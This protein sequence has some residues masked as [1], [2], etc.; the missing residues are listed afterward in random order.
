MLAFKRLNQV[1]QSSK[2]IPISNRS[3]I[4][5]MSDC[6]R[7]DGSAADDFKPNKRLYMHA[8][9]HYYRAGYTYIEI[10]DADELWENRSFRRILKAHEDVFLLLR[11]FHVAKRFYVIW[12]NH[13]IVKRS[14][15]YLSYNLYY[16]RDPHTRARVPLLEG[17]ES[18]EGLILRHRESNARVFVVHGHQADFF[19]DQLWPVSCMLVRYV[20]RP[21]EILGI[22]DPISPAKNHKKR[23]RVE[24]VLERWS[25]DNRQIV[26][27][28]H[29][30]RPSLPEKG[31]VPY[32]NDGSC[33][34]KDCVTA[35]EISRGCMVLVRW[36]QQQRGRGPL[37]TVRQVIGGPLSL[38]ELQM[39]IAQRTSSAGARMHR[40]SQ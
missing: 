35:I 14:R 10:G 36:C 37:V 1:F 15:Q 25:R 19:N 3:R 39:R 29:T 21:L 30:H 28:G 7:G 17:L 2:E 27:A 8:L 11:K 9:E 18:H 33:V 23:N 13:D 12:G 38:A 20:W 34:H 5:F 40:Y 26:I 24:S 31:L 16:R 4:V 6:H 32:A 22:Q